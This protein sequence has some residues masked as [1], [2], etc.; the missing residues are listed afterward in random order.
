MGWAMS[1]KLRNNGRLEG[2][3]GQVGTV[4]GHAREGINWICKCACQQRIITV[5]RAVFVAREGPMA[6]V[7]FLIIFLDN[8]VFKVC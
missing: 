3:E 6:A 8:P 2:L 5:I 4:W 7:A 1:F